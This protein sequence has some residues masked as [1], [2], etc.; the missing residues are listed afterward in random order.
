[1][2]EL[3]AQPKQELRTT[4]ASPQ[5]FLTVIARAASDPNIDVEKMERLLAM[6]E[7]MMAKQAEMEFNQDFTVMQAEMP[8]IKKNGQIVIREVLQSRFAKFEDIDTVIR[9]IMSKYG[10]SLSF[11]S[12]QAPDGQKVV[13]YATLAHKAGHSIPGEIPLAVD[14]SGSKN[15]VQGVGSTI[16]YGK[17]YLATMLLNLVFEGEDDDGQS[18]GRGP[19]ITEDQVNWVRD[20]L[21]AT[22]SDEARFLKFMDAKSVTMI[23]AKSFAKAETML[24]KK[25]NEVK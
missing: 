1:M 25:L 17:R 15:N 18:A 19:L 21:L 2:T 22:N 13:I 7:R 6:Q 5:Q 16:S 4:E 20:T 3:T 11:N 12:K 23:P 10:F 24:V 8:R 9:P 14:A